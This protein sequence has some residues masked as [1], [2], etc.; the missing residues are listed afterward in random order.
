MDLTIRARLIFS[1]E[2]R[3]SVSGV[4]GTGVHSMDVPAER[5]PISTKDTMTAES[6]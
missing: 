4:G 3:G 6:G 5:A 1:P 2:C